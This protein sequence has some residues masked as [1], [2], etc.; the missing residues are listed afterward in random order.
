MDLKSLHRKDFPDPTH[1]HPIPYELREKCVD[2]K[3]QN[4]TNI[5]LSFKSLRARC[6]RPPT[7]RCKDFKSVENYW[8][9]PKTGLMLARIFNF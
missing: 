4:K 1:P 9:I 7:L 5:F 6:S 8:T 2:F 3:L